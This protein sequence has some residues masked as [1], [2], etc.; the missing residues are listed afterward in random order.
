MNNSGVMKNIYLSY[1]EKVFRYVRGK[2]SNVA[3][4][5]DVT[6]EIFLKIQ[7]SLDSYNEEKATLSTW[8]YTITHNAVCNFYRDESKRALPLDENAL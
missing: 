3:D 8:I 5:E 2:V 1:K 4:A 6:S 7:T